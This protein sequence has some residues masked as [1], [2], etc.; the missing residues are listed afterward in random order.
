MDIEIK[1]HPTSYQGP[2]LQSCERS[3]GSEGE[4]NYRLQQGLGTSSSDENLDSQQ[5]QLKAC[6]QEL[7]EL[8]DQLR[9]HAKV[10]KHLQ[11]HEQRFKDTETLLNE[12]YLDMDLVEIGGD[13]P[14]MDELRADV[15][16]IS[17][18]MTEELHPTTREPTVMGRLFSAFGN[19]QPTT[20][21]KVAPS[22]FD[23]V[24][25]SMGMGSGGLNSR[26]GWNAGFRRMNDDEEEAYML[27]QHGASPGTSGSANGDNG[28]SLMDLSRM[29]TPTR[30]PSSEYMS[31]QG[32][33]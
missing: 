14:I 32:Y 21:F 15:S 33:L 22:S 28:S 20:P 4:N 9:R 27:V 8:R 18:D 23:P 13:G 11:K 17:E 2:P 3:S 6:Q 1:D 25:S 16:S 7:F 5:Q 29:S 24:H 12:Y 31:S 30:I 26:P 10:L 19:R